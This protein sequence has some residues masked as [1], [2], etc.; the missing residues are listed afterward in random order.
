MGSGCPEGAV[1]VFLRLLLPSVVV[2]FGQ[3]QR[4]L[5]RGLEPNAGAVDLFFLHVLNVVMHRGG[6]VESVPV[7]LFRRPYCVFRLPQDKLV[8]L[9][10][11]RPRDASFR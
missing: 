5:L 8:V 11:G 9:L 7:S 1:D 2:F 6:D 10:H 3:G 4:G